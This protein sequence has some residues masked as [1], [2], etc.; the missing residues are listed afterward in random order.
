M[1]A[2][3][4]PCQLSTRM[5]PLPGQQVQAVTVTRLHADGP[6]GTQYLA[7][8]AV[9]ARLAVPHAVLGDSKWGAISRKRKAMQG[10]Q[11]NKGLGRKV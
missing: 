8:W 11:R 2:A 4:R 5:V 3:V 6:V 1:V 10:R 7:W 9:A